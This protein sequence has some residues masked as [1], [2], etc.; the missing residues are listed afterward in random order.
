MRW[1]TIA[2]LVAMAYIIIM[3]TFVSGVLNGIIEGESQLF[4]TRERN[5]QTLGEVV[6]GVFIFM[7]GFA[8]FYM[9]HKASERRVGANKMII[10]G[11]TVL[12]L[13]LIAA[14]ALLVIKL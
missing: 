13:V 6:L 12:A 10:A 9:L 4:I 2:T 7:A 11:F 5:V 14:Y 8:G 1:Q 3:F